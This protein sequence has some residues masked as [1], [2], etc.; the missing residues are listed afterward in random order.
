MFK[1]ILFVSLVFVISFLAVS[2]SLAE[3]EENAAVNAESIGEV[4]DPGILPGSPFY[5]I[6][7][8]GRSLKMFFTFD[9]AKKARLELK[10]ANEDI[11]SLKEL[12]DQ[13]KCDLAKKLSEKYE[14]KMEKVNTRIETAKQKGEDVE[15]LIQNLKD[16]YARHQQILLRVLEKAPEQARD[17]LMNAMENSEKGLMNAVEKIE[18]NEARIQLRNQLNSQIRNEVENMGQETR[19]QVRQKWQE[20]FNEIEAPDGS[21]LPRDSG[22]SGNPG[23]SGNNGI[24][25][26]KCGD[27]ICQEMVCLGSGCP[28]AET[29]LSCPADCSSAN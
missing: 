10:Y 25:A 29:V 17:G 21:T 14:A 18:S 7:N 28:C 13:G 27:G 15:E 3:T 9:S 11:L 24:C 4:S 20:R 1:K 22:Q 5:F 26:D 23:N 6:K 16:N 2:Q 8:L 12:C 19:L